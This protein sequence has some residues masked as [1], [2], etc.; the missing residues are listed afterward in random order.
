MPES[1]F[2][3]IHILICWIMIEIE[4]AQAMPIAP[5]FFDKYIPKNI[6]INEHIIDMHI[7]VSLC[8]VIL[9]TY[10]HDPVITLTICEKLKIINIIDPFL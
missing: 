7:I 3:N 9:R 6:A 5:Y 1:R 8:H 2:A 4:Y 10:E